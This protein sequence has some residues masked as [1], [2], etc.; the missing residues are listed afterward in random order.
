MMGAR[1]RTWLIVCP[2]RSRAP[3]CQASSR[4]HAIMQFSVEMTTELTGGQTVIRKAKLNMVDLAGSEKWN[5]SLS[6][7]AHR[8][9]ELRA[10][11]KVRPRGS[12]CGVGFLMR[13]GGGQS[14]SAL[15]NIIAALSEAKRRHIPYRDS[16]LTRLLQVHAATRD[17]VCARAI[18]QQLAPCRRTRWAATRARHSSPPSPPWH[19]R[20]PSRVPRSP[21]RTAHALS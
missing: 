11:N 5:T 16:I 1:T 12:G 14:L 19:P 18:T 8:T 15:G 20:A 6:L 4:S 21:S 9:A 3:P 10:I 7:D 13:R 2:A 17:C